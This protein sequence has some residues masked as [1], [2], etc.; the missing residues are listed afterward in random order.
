MAFDPKVQHILDSDDS[1]ALAD[2]IRR[3]PYMA[4]RRVNGDMNVLLK[5]IGDG[6]RNIVAW[7]LAPNNK[8]TLD[9]EE[10]TDGLFTA[11]IQDDVPTLCKLVSRGANIHVR[12]AIGETPLHLAFRGYGASVR[13]LVAQGIDVNIRDNKGQTILHETSNPM[14][15]RTLVALGADLNALDDSG[16]TPLHL[17]MLA[18]C[19][20][21]GSLLIALG[22]DI[23]SRDIQGRTP[24]HQAVISRSSGILLMLIAYGADVNTQDNAGKTPLQSLQEDDWDSCFGPSELTH[25]EALLRMLQ[26]A[27]LGVHLRDEGNTALLLA[28]ENDVVE[29]LPFL[30]QQGADVCATNSNNWNA[31]QMALATESLAC[32]LFLRHTMPLE[33]VWNAAALGDTATV[34][35]A[36]EIGFDINSQDAQRQTLLMLAA[37][38]RQT[39]AVRLLLERGAQPDIYD[40]GGFTALMLTDNLEIATLL[41]GHG[42]TVEV[43]SVRY[44][45]PLAIA[46]SF[47][48]TGMVS[49]LL[50]HGAEVFSD[51]LPGRSALALAYAT[52]NIEIIALLEQHIP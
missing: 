49:L 6:R 15:I 48:R 37:I 47:E 44:W 46:V 18:N 30:L 9:P 29:A 14:C 21:V 43:C 3:T 28:A 2:M 8:V 5:A 12:N 42:A 51:E 50:K 11:A 20:W 38:Y 13:F 23:K 22:A 4:D 52:G 45:T 41:I 39:E 33:G 26:E 34:Q 24:L 7:L 35:S 1:A 32:A 31:L 16:H 25:P 19:E 17:N 27:Y 10:I 40:L 36:L